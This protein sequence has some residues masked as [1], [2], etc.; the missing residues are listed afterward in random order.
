MKQ[1]RYR[2]YHE[3]TKD[4]GDVSSINWSTEK[5]EFNS[6][7][8]FGDYNLSECIL[9]LYTGLM[10][11]NGNEICEGDIV[12]GVTSKLYVVALDKEY[13]GFYPFVNDGGCG[14]C[15]DFNSELSKNCEIIGNVYKNPELLKEE[16]R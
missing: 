9:M 16:I 7:D 10:D 6:G 12:S 3:T 1:Y 5:V 15:S 14:C 13:A 2:A 4:I 11:I 8:G